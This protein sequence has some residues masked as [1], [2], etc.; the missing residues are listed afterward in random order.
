MQRVLSVV[1]ARPVQNVAQVTDSPTEP[2]T[3]SSHL[4]SNK[5]EFQ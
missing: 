3:V 1:T 5:S 4:K 2:A